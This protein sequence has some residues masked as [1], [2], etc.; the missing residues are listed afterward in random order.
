MPNPHPVE[1]VE[2]RVLE[3][4]PLMKIC[5]ADEVKT[6]VPDKA[7]DNEK[8]TSLTSWPAEVGF[9]SRSRR[10]TVKNP[11]TVVNVAE[12]LTLPSPT[13]DPG[14]VE[15]VMVAPE[16]NGLAINRQKTREVNFNAVSGISSYRVTLTL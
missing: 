7:V 9:G 12:A 10:I 4:S 14:A 5:C 13:D 15:N 1:A 16:A 11:S 3:P 6:V 8:S 2:P